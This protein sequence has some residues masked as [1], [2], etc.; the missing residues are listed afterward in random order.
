[1][2]RERS[3]HRHERIPR[4]TGTHERAH[5][6]TEWGKIRGTFEGLPGGKDAAKRGAQTRAANGLVPFQRVDDEDDGLGKDQA[7]DRG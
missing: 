1:M 2:K 6:E 4:D 5:R 3:D 7:A